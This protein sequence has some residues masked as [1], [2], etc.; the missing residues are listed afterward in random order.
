[1][2]NHG[3][4]SHG[5]KQGSK[6]EYAGAA[7]FD[8]SQEIRD[9]ARVSFPS[10]VT[11]L[12]ADGFRYSFTELLITRLWSTAD[13]SWKTESIEFWSMR[14]GH[15]PR[16]EKDRIELK[17]LPRD[18]IIREAFDLS[19]PAVPAYAEPRTI[20]LMAGGRGTVVRREPNRAPFSSLR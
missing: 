17:A 3:W 16:G 14:S 8:L 11:H 18:G 19:M 5:F 12:T 13:R 4:N 6:L 15:N 20:E 1:M 7:R 9:V 2:G 10:P